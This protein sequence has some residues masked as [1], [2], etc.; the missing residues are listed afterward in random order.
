MNIG[1]D[2]VA[3]KKFKTIKRSD[4]KHWSRVFSASEWK[5]AFGYASSAEH[6]AG[7]FVAKE[8][9]M[10]ATGFVGAKN[11]KRFEIKH[12]RQGAPKINIKGGKVSISHDQNMAVAVVLVQ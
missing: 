10:K 3:I 2:L 6:L 7:I 11:Y 8:A 4:Y 9:A 1:I 5:Y 12:D